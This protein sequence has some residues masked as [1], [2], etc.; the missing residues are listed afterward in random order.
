MAQ[1]A[2]KLQSIAPGYIHSP[3]LDATV[4][5]AGGISPSASALLGPA[6]EE[7]AVAAPAPSSE[8]LTASDPNGAISL[9]EA[10]EKQLGLK[11][12]L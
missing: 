5:K 8:V 4:S 9:P 7:T 12:E 10:I 6:A 2:E 1:Y 11:L 3:V